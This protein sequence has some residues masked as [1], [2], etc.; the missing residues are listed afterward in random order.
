MPPDPYTDVV[1]Q[2]VDLSRAANSDS[3]VNFYWNLTLSDADWANYLSESISV[4]PPDDKDS[5]LM[6]KAG[7][8]KDSAGTYVAVSGI[9]KPRIN[10][11]AVTFGKYQITSYGLFDNSN[12]S[13]PAYD[14]LRS[15]MSRTF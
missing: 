9:W 8:V 4:I 15:P 10:I 1:L 11:S 6:S 3:E 14:H 7:L 2:V 5:G 13:P 12:N